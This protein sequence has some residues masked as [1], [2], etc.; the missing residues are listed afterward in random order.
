MSNKWAVMGVAAAG[1][2]GV[3]AIGGTCIYLLSK[4][5]EEFQR[6]SKTAP[7]SSS[8]PVHIHVQV[9]TD[10]VGKVIGRGGRHLKEI[11]VKT[12]TRIHFKDEPATEDFRLLDISGLPEDVKFAEVLIYQ[13]IANFPAQDRCIID[14]PTAYIGNV[15]GRDGDVVRSLEL[16]TGCKIDIE[17]RSAVE[18]ETRKVTLSGSAQQIQSARKLIAQIVQEWETIDD[19]RSSAKPTVSQKEQPLFLTSD[20]HSEDT[21]FPFKDGRILSEELT[22]TSQD[23]TMEIYVSSVSNPEN[24]CV[25][26]VGPLSIELDKLVTNMTSYYE[27]NS[28]D[29]VLST[30]AKGDIVA[31]KNTSDGSYYR[32]KV[33]EVIQN[34]YDES[35]VQV[36]LNFLDYGVSE[37][38]SRQECFFL[39]EE[40]LK[41]KAQAIHCKLADIKP[42]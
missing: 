22:P 13:I 6:N 8:R 12:N 18:T 20:C 10:H 29:C 15:I 41:L 34:D 39:P 21:A 14:V 36:V 1:L 23:E 24:F 30:C 4:E 38:K 5:E 42:Q 33:V 3:A 27:E 28:Q 25:Q 17:R 40:Y 7:H 11:E 35:D 9:P 31:A 2:V 19:F 37:T 32:G 16:K 26:K